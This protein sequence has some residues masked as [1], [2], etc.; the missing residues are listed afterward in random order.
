MEQL[1]QQLRNGEHINFDNEKFCEQNQLDDFRNALC[2]FRNEN[3][4]TWANGFSIRFNGKCIHL[5]K[6]F[7]SF[8]NKLNKLKAK[9][10]LDQTNE[11]F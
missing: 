9:W 11:D 5:S 7:K 2:T 1:E 3:N 8:E 4:N 6:T 10:N